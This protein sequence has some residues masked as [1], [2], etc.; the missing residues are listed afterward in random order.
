M[1]IHRTPVLPGILGGL[2]ALS[3]AIS[4]SAFA[5][6]KDGK[7]PGAHSSPSATIAAD[8]ATSEHASFSSGNQPDLKPGPAWKT[9]GGTVKHIK[10]DMLTIEDYE[11]NQVQLYVSQDTKRLRGH[12]KPGD[13]VR[14]EITRDGFANSIQ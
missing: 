4:P 8:G 1:K 2:A 14:A 11:G 12:K 9:I 10:G 7:K 13:Q 3:L 5:G 6:S